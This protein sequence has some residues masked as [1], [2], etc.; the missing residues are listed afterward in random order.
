MAYGDLKVRNLIWN[1]GSGDNTVVLSTLATQSY[2]TTNF[3]PKANPTFTG[4]INGA[5]LIL[6]GNLTVNGTQTIIN[7]Q[8]L[9]VEDKQ[10]EI[11]KVSSPSDTTADQGGWKLK[12]ATDKTFLWLNATDAWTSS[13]HIQVASGKTFIGDGS[14]LTALNATNLASG[15]VPTARLGSGT[16]GSANF[17]RGDGS[18]QAI[19]TDKIEEGNTSVE[20]V[21]TGSDGHVKITTE[22]TERVRI[23]AD[24]KV[25]IGD[26]S[27]TKPLTVGTTTPV[28]LLDDQSSRTLEIRGP[29]ATHNATVLTT[30]SHD[31]LLGTNNS[32]RFRIGGSAGQL[33]IGG[34]NYGTSGQVLTSGG[35]SAAPSWTSISAA[36]EITA[37]AG[38]ALTAGDACIINSSGQAIKVAETISES[39]TAQ[40]SYAYDGTGSN[41]YSDS[42]YNVEKDRHVLL[43]KMNGTQAQPWIM[44]WNGSTGTSGWDANALTSLDTSSTYGHAV[45]TIDGGG[46]RVL[47]AYTKSNAVKLYIGT[48]NSA[49]D[50]ITWSTVSSNIATAANS[51][52]GRLRLVSCGTNK[53]ALIGPFSDG[54]N[55]Y[56]VGCIILSHNGSG[57][58]TAGSQ[59]TIGGYTGYYS[60]PSAAYDS[61]NDRLLVSFSRNDSSTAGA[62]VKICT[63][64]GTS[65]TAG[66][67]CTAD[68]SAADNDGDDRHSICYDE[69]SGKVLFLWQDGNSTGYAVGTYNTGKTA[70][71]WATGTSLTSQIRKQ[72][73]L[74]YDKTIKKTMIYYAKQ[75]SGSYESLQARILTVSGS[76][77]TASSAVTDSLTS[78][79]NALWVNAMGMNYDPVNKMCV[80]S[81]NAGYS[82]AAI[83]GI[84]GGTSSTNASKFTG[85]ATGAVSSGAAA[86]LAVT[87]NTTDD[88]SGLTTGEIHY[89]TGDGGLSTTAADPI[90]EAGIALSATK[91]LIKG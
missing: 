26:S 57:T 48:I 85:F 55:A 27:P 88:Q 68:T 73:G 25:G 1:T 59:T 42:C 43:L 67:L 2:V 51:D 9:D 41:S 4:T 24:G 63:I 17:L 71:T 35:A 56:R 8:T 72:K 5:D 38:E 69:A 29:S 45:C 37:T 89:L 19:A 39:L 21:D 11:G 33:G 91:L 47:A 15:T 79:R 52:T 16:A 87:G 14:T 80:A 23:I 60:Y 6:S 70:V 77:I 40:S 34:A 13:E 31:L 74:C 61:V 18:W 53:C 10:I 58:I 20:T 66:S 36:P 28:I 83:W 30:S 84:K 75:Q 86:T 3:A 44:S 12:G 81:F 50:S 64:S 7:T 49:G 32:E 65:V 46:G 82:Q 22:G 76:N 78:S 90:I 54:T 62:Y